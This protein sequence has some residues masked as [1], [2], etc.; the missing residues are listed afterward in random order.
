MRST[1]RSASARASSDRLFAAAAIEF[2]TC[3]FAGARVDRIA[4]SARVSKGLVYYYFRGKKRLYQGLLAKILTALLAR[5]KEVNAEAIPPREKIEQIIREYA[6]FFLENPLYAII[7]LRNI[8]DRAVHNNNEIFKLSSAAAQEI[9]QVVKEGVRQ[10]FFR[11]VRPGFVHFA[12]FHPILIWIAIEPER[13]AM[14]ALQL[15]SDDLSA[16]LFIKNLQT[17][18]TSWLTDGL[19]RTREAQPLTANDVESSGRLKPLTRLR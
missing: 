15:P 2:A 11:D 1:D 8:A 9:E 17:A 16:E 10:G 18:A 4:R 12:F 13:A 5:I 19:V 6:R 14:A 7:L 3:G